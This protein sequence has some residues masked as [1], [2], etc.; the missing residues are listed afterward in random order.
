M[1]LQGK[2]KPNQTKKWLWDKRERWEGGLYSPKDCSP[3]NL[4]SWMSKICNQYEIL[5][6]DLSS[7]IWG[8]QELGSGKNL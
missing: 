6:W 5:T 4:D 7:L 1:F 2:T 3:W 8:L